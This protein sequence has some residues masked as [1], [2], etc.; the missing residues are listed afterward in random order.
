MQVTHWECTGE[1]LTSDLLFDFFAYFDSGTHRVC[2]LYGS[3]ETMG[4]VTYSVF[5]SA[6]DAGRQLSTNSGE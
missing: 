1:P 3:T 2:N 4:D 5:E 6:D